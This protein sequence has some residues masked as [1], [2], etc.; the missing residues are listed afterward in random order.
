MGWVRV[1]LRLRLSLGLGLGLG[2]GG[3]VHIVES[4]DARPY[5]YP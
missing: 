3:L 5:P 4:R 1:R 2:S